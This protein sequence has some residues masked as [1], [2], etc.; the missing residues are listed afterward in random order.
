MP[1]WWRRPLRPA[2]CPWQI[3]VCSPMLLQRP[4]VNHASTLLFLAVLPSTP[5]Q[6]L[7]SLEK[8]T[9]AACL[10]ILMRLAV[11]LA[12][13]QAALSQAAVRHSPV[14]VMVAWA[15]SHQLERRTRHTAIQPIRTSL[16]VVQAVVQITDTAAVMA[17]GLSVFPL[18]LSNLTARSSLTAELVL[19]IVPVGRVV[20]FASIPAHS[21]ALAMFT[22]VV[23]TGW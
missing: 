15:E 18:V 12:L 16:A 21:P 22:P 8:A 13:P 4:P 6:R 3:I 9:L 23:A 7:M 10:I 20:A 2:T 5:P 11:L 19:S 17:V 14:A 1:P